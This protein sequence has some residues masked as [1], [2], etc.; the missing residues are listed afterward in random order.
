MSAATVTSKGQITIPADVREECGIE[1]GDRIE[2]F[3]MA[4]GTI[5][6]RLLNATADDFFNCLAGFENTGFTGTDDEAIALALLK[7]DRGEEVPA[8]AGAPR[9]ERSPAAPKIRKPAA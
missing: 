2:L 9:P 1:P 5:H 3:P 4:D 6:L 7:D 8:K